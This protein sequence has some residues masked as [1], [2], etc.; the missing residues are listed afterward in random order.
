MALLKRGS[1]K[2]GRT[3]VEFEVPALGGSL[4]ASSLESLGAQ[5]DLLEQARLNRGEGLPK[6]FAAAVLD[7]DGEPFWSAE[8]WSVWVGGHMQEAMAIEV[9][10][11]RAWGVGRDAM[12]DAKKN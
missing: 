8:D 11:L 3:R 7:G 4:L 1:A 10:V 5:L 6:L 12:D 9:A 2:A